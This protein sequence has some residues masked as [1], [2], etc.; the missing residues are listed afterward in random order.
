MELGRES[1]ATVGFPLVSIEPPDIRFLD[2]IVIACRPCVKSLWLGT[3]VFVGD[4]LAAAEVGGS[5]AMTG[6]SLIDRLKPRVH[7]MNHSYKTIWNEQTNTYV[8]VGEN[9]SGRG[10]RSGS[11]MIAVTGLVFAV[12]CGWS[13][14]ASAGYVI[15][16]NSLISAPNGSGITCARPGST[17]SWT[18]Q[19][20]SENGGVAIISGIQETEL[21]NPLPAAEAW[22]AQSLAASAIAVGNHK[23]K[24]TGK[25][26]IAIGLEAEAKGEG[27]ISIGTGAG[28][29]SQGDKNIA[30]GNASSQENASRTIV[31]GEQAKAKTSDVIALGY[32]AK[33][34]GKRG[35]AIGYKTVAQ[36]D[37]G[38]AV[39]ARAE[40]SSGAI[41]I[42][43]SDE[44][45][46]AT[47]AGSNAAIAIG[48]RTR[49]LGISTTAIGTGAYAFGVGST[50]V[51][52]AAGG[53]TEGKYN[54]IMGYTA[55]SSM[56]GD[57][58]VAVGRN[59]LTNAQVPKGAGEN[60]ALGVN[61]GGHITGASNAMAGAYAGQL[62]IG[63]YNSLLG[64][65]A[66]QGMEGSNNVAIGLQ[67]GKK[68]KVKDSV[69]IG[70]RAQALFDGSVALGESSRTDKAVATKSVVINGKH[71]DFSGTNPQSTVSVGAEGKERTITRVAAGRVSDSSTDVVNG[72][73]LHATNQAL[74]T[75]GGATLTFK[76][77]T[78]S[79]ERKLGESLLVAGDAN[80]TTVVDSSGVKVALK[81]DLI[82]LNSV[83]AKSVNIGGGSLIA[84]ASGV[85]FGAGKTI[86][87]SNNQIT[88]VA[89]GSDD[90]HAVNLSQLKG[91]ADIA[92]L[93]W[94]LSTNG[95]AAE[96]VAPGGTVDFSSSDDN[97][98]LTQAGTEIDLKLNEDLTGLNSVASKSINIGNGMF[99]ANEIGVWVK[100]G[101][102]INMGGNKVTNVAAGSEDMDAVNYGQLKNVS[103]NVDSLSDRAVKYDQN[104]DGSVNKGQVT[105]EGDTSTD[106][107][108]T[109]GTKFNNVARG[110]I[111]E[112]STD[113]V[114]GSQLHE[115]GDSIAKGMGGNSTF[116]DG[117]LVTAL[118]V[119][120]NTY[121]SVNDALG[122]LDGRIGEV[123]AEA[124]KGWNIQANGDSSSQVALGDTVQFLDGENIAIT[125]QGTEV[126]IGMAKD[127][128]VESVTAK[129]V[130]ASSVETKEVRIENG[131]VID[132]NGIDMRDKAI[133][134][135]A[136]GK[137]AQDAVN[138]RQ[139]NQV[140]GGLQGQVNDLRS[141]LHRQKNE[142]RAGV[143]AAM[144][145]ASL[146]QAY[147]PGKTMM[148][149][150]GATWNGETGMAIGFSGISDSGHWVYKLSGNASS[151]GDYGGGVGIGY[152]W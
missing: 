68:S 15:D 84:N 80:I 144:A 7:M 60:T 139:L 133:S 127:I 38:V 72:S 20:P 105:M 6:E 140:A 77:D 16:G 27:N 55:G 90:T 112:N 109:G 50:V 148:A 79:T 83:S 33:G 110:D 126:T 1:S 120:G 37:D 124:S 52:N 69:A 87:M 95:G 53:G 135:V 118:D 3:P 36:H 149:M 40:A 146:P 9:V 88:N 137:A 13:E 117:K 134:N 99:T 35:I 41:A 123:A 66:G 32:Q 59:S 138:V 97:I 49:A 56:Q 57:D 31:I 61:A 43:S 12:A 128:K 75:L 71:Y 64:Y 91:V 136:D 143:A 98:V 21:N 92:N 131:P 114:N 10:K 65:E 101:A 14:M 46:E 102:T 82:G 89:A 94:G 39:G 96:N 26:S 104:A 44:T 30:I 151:R 122:G 63:D 119:G 74:E 73:Q 81:E 47:I 108:R 106:G 4:Y 150:S 62:S 48:Q 116:V 115:M 142:L 51:G 17:G 8:A 42:G 25:N 121:N 54:T 5:H 111:S 103:N 93:G 18:C 152:Q 58:N 70:A 85:V 34:E 78:G 67:A 2:W 147:L 100:N 145:T 11:V 86:N 132:Q 19:I 23:T 76:G 125:R 29:S 141:D 130:I 45:Q 28:K 113:A 107:G 24:A 129:T 22:K